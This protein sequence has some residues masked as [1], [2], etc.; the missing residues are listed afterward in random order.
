M[1][2]ILGYCGK[3]LGRADYREIQSNFDKRNSLKL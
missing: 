1:T 3:T 2:L